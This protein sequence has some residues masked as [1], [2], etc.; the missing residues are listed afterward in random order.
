MNNSKTRN[1]TKLS[2]FI[3]TIVLTHQNTNSFQTPVSHTK[4][5]IHQMTSPINVMSTGT[6]NTI[7]TANDQLVESVLL[8]SNQSHEPMRALPDH[9]QNSEFE[10]KLGKAIDTLRKDYP[11]LLTHPPNYSIYDEHL[12]IVDPSGVTLHSLS[13]YKSS[14]RFLHML[15]K[16][17]YCPKKSILTF[18]LAYDCARKNIRVSWNA[19]LVPR[20]FG[21]ELDG[22]V[23]RRNLVHVDGISVYELDRE[24]GLIVQHRVERLLVNDAPVRSESNMFDL[25]YEKAGVNARLGENG[26]PV[27]YK[28]EGDEYYDENMVMN[29]LPPSLLPRKSMLFSMEDDDNMANHELFDEVAFQKKNKSRQKFGLKPITEAEFV[30]IEIKTKELEKA[31]QQKAASISS[32]AEMNM[33]KE[34]AKKGNFMNKLF[35]NLSK[36]TCQDNWDC[37]RPEVCC[38]FGFKKMCCSSGMKVF[39]GLPGQLQKIPVRVVADDDQ[40]Q[41]RGGPEGTDW[42]Y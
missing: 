41:R 14:F 34:D 26:I 37:Q 21:E 39:N 38:D 31:Q 15:V 36:D 19:K 9:E 22:S 32:A 4:R 5:P 24:T 12:T 2:L 23:N 20:L 13:G 7:T 33:S 42:G 29:F 28:E 8:A 18:K 27:F 11:T 10:L 16:L 35:G 1:K 30:Q 17:F 6:S 3:M 40:W 25:I